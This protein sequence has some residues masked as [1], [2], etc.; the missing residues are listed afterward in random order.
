MNSNAI[1]SQGTAIKPEPVGKFKQF[2]TEAFNIGKVLAP[3]ITKASEAT[4]NNVTSTMLAGLNNAGD[5]SN[6]LAPLGDLPKKI[7]LGR[8]D[9]QSNALFGELISSISNRYQ[10]R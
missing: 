6:A 2:L 7:Y 10:G 1:D 5:F 3:V 8:P 9:G 4:A